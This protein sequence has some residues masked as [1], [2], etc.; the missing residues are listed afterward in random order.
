MRPIPATLSPTASARRAAARVYGKTSG[1]PG[2]HRDHRWD[3]RPIPRLPDPI[4]SV[5]EQSRH[6]WVKMPAETRTS[7]AAETGSVR[8]ESGS[9]LSSRVRPAGVMLQV[10][11]FPCLSAT[12]TA[13][14]CTIPR[15]A[16]RRASIR[17]MPPI[18]ASGGARRAGGSR[19]IW[20]THWHPDHAG[21]NAAIK[22]ATGCTVIGP[23]VDAA[24][25]SP[26]ST[27]R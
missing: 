20:N 12:I 11:Q 3:D 22:A 26:E 2:R 4:R 10:H 17:P 7:R 16:R 27:G 25:R 21:G 15:A 1:F 23:A 6:H 5:Y 24:R 19:Q 9:F 8:G 13:S 18:L 14:C